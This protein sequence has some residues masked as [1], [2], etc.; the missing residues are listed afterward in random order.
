MFCIKIYLSLQCLFIV[1]FCGAKLA[2]AVKPFPTNVLHPVT[3]K[4]GHTLV[5]SG[6]LKR[7]MDQDLNVSSR[8]RT[9]KPTERG[10][11][12]QLAT[13][14]D[15]L[16]GKGRTLMQLITDPTK[17]NETAKAFDHWKQDYVLFVQTGKELCKIDKGQEADFTTMLESVNVVKVS[18]EE[19]LTA[20]YKRTDYDEHHQDKE[21]KLQA[22]FE[23]RASTMSSA[24]STG[25]TRS[26]RSARST[27]SKLSLL[28]LEESQKKVELTSKTA[29]LK[30]KQEI[31]KKKME[32]KWQEEQLDLESEIEVN[33][34]KTKLIEEAVSDLDHRE[35]YDVKQRRQEVKNQGERI[36]KCEEHGA[37]KEKS[38]QVQ[39]EK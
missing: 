4:Q 11:S 37:K 29:L 15:K 7:I 21:G 33:A 8:G 9:L 6:L 22:N 5:T 39:D 17:V 14:N 18:V 13:L 26:S 31:E 25:S 23:D 27:R 24:L 32:L 38:Q 35:D 28:R 12:Y 3:L 10:A 1:F 20:N 19:Y 34:A 36:E 16:Q 30:K 2:A